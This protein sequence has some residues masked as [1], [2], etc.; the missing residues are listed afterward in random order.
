MSDDVRS[1]LDQL[2]QP[3]LE[4][5]D[6]GESAETPG[7][8]PI[9]RLVT[10]HPAVS[11]LPGGRRRPAPGAPSDAVSAGRRATN[12]PDVDRRVGGQGSIFRRYAGPPETAPTPPS[13]QGDDIR[14]L[15]RRLS[16]A[17]ES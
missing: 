11:R 5:R 17:E 4:Y 8:W 13:P 16:G 6:F 1:L 2:G 14:G 7:F 9:F 10:A 3:D 12:T 15:L